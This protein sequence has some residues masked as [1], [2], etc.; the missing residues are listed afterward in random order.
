MT[1][2]LA[3]IQQAL[4]KFRGR[5]TSAFDTAFLAKTVQRR[6]EAT[7][8]PSRADYARQLQED[9]REAAA[10]D[11]ALDVT[12][13]DFFRGPFAFALLEQTVLPALLEAMP[14]ANGS[15]VRVWSA[16][17][18]TGQEAWSVA[19]LLEDLSVARQRRL[20]F[21]VFASDASEPALATARAGVYPAHQL[22]NLRLRHVEDY[23]TVRGDRYTITPRLRERV[24]FS[25]YD[26]LDSASIS[27]PDSL[28]GDFHLILC[29]NVLYYYRPAVQQRLLAKLAQALTPGGWLVTGEVERDVALRHRSFRVLAPPAPVFQKPAP[30]AR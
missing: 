4:R 2:D 18:A 21:R 13:T 3:S 8:L 11:A 23:F 25:T 24:N 7:Q 26:L 28:F 29:C 22:R 1:N 10:L 6:L 17:C 12:H 27:P 9:E 15:E 30:A 20:A 5:D 19:M 14:V 16:G